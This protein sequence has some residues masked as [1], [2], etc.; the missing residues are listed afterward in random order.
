LES[1]LAAYVKTETLEDY[2]QLMI[3]DMQGV[4]ARLKLLEEKTRSPAAGVKDS[5]GL[6]ARVAKLES[7]PLVRYHGV[8]SPDTEYQRG[9]LVTSGGSMW[10]CWHTTRAKP[11]ESDDWQLC[12]KR[13][14]PGKD[15]R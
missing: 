6:E 1:Q 15:A 4:Q 12:V 9:D 10:H 5:Q 14:S 3:A 11:G 8:W 7:R 13:G 2:I